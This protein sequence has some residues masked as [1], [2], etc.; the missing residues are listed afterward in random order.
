M[1]QLL[2]K[3]KHVFSPNP[4]GPGMATAVEHSIDTGDAQPIKQRAYRTSQKEDQYMKAEIDEMIENEIIRPS[5]SPWSSPVVLVG[6]KDGT[7][8]FCVDYR[9]V[10]EVTKKDS[11]PI[12]RI[13]E[14]LDC[15]N[16]SKYFTS[17]D[18]ASGYWQIKVKGDHVAKTAFIC[19]SGLFE[20]VRM[21]FGLCNAPSTFQRAM[22]ILLT[23][24]NWK[25]A[26]IYID[27][28]LVFSRNFE[29]HLAHLE[30][31]LQRLSNAQFTVKLSKC[32]F[33]REEVSYLGHV[34][35]SQGIKPDPAKLA[36]V[37]DFKVPINLTEVRSFLGL[38][39]YYHR[40]V[41]AYATVAEPL[42]YLQKKNVHFV[43]TEK[44]QTAFDH[45][46]KMLV[47]SPTLRYPNFE[48][49]FI[50]MT[51]A[52]NVGLGAVLSQV[53]DNKVEYAI[54]YASRAL[55]AEERNY[56]TTEKECLAVLFSIKTFRPYLHDI[57]HHRY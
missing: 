32:F 27:D 50:V 30:L 39:T 4:K 28:I 12:P 31:V 19:K 34:V 48:R 36:A 43:W 41:P 8:R 56:S 7:L 37:G 33:G 6:K 54:S 52:S 25:F 16:G 24:L 49:E 44:C 46:K 9:K 22:D 35:N 18:F 1:M 55:S 29:E 38:T 47:S 20:F 53:D 26:L 11:Y 3:Y 42:Y 5:A 2:K 23:G 14:A 15:L 21:P 51:D 10:N 45:I 13:T 17:L 57:F 40:F